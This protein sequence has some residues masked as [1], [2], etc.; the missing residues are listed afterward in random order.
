MKRVAVGLVLIATIA[1]GVAWYV[2]RSAK[3]DG[4][5][6]GYVEGYIVYAAP[7]EGGRIETLAV[8]SGSQ[9]KVG[10]FLFAIE[11]STQRAQ[12]DEAQA[13]L[14][15]ARSQLD[16]LQAALQRPEEIAVLKAQEERAQ[17]EFELSNI[18]LNRQQTLFN[19][20]ISAKAQLDQAKTSYERDKA[21]LQTV[22]RQIE[23]GQIAGRK[24]EISAAEANVRV[25]QA[26][27]DQA[28][29]RL[30]K[31]S[32]NAAVAA[33]V[34]DVFFRPGEVVNAGQPV[35][36][37]L[38]PLNRRIRFYVPEPKLVGLALGDVV[39]VACDNCP[40]D[41][42]AKITFM[43]RQVEY[44]PPVIFS[45]EERAKLVFRIEAQPVGDAVLPVGLPVSVFA[46]GDRR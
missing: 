38:P 28:E 37:L 10:Q 29:T 15:Q 36:A 14:Q 42:T 41:L 43:S 19:R 25:T 7:E 31:L 8:D 23:A 12:R 33:Q 30:G 17:A 2:L 24:A 4:S 34:Q 1:A 26:A 35:L 11:S 32:V 16:N 13:R 46:G 3:V 21:A 18:E 5:F 27:L 40:G 44:T 39:R 45:Q 9:V 22:Q 20:G 6:Q